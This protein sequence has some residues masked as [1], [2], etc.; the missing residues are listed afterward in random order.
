MI[1]LSGTWPGFTGQS[2]RLQ[3]SNTGTRTEKTPQSIP[4]RV[5]CPVDSWG[6]GQQVPSSV[7]ERADPIPPPGYCIKWARYS[8]S[9][10]RSAHPWLEARTG[11]TTS[12]HSCVP[13]RW[14]YIPM[15]MQSHRQCTP[16]RSAGQGTLQYACQESQL[17][18]SGDTTICVSGITAQQL[19]ATLR[20]AARQPSQ[21]HEL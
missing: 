6:R 8:A 7:G 1:T 15:L 10:G 5:N 14:F 16:E 17:C 3:Q 12:S 4:T 21:M 9:Q 19:E 20:F 13:S 18:W 2:R 11:D